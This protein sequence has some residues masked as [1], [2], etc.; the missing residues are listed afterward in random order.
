MRLK[1]MPDYGCYPLWSDVR[2]GDVDPSSLPLSDGLVADLLEWSDF[3]DSKLVWDDP[4]STHWSK[5]EAVS[6]NALGERLT[7][8][9]AEELGPGYAVRYFQVISESDDE[10]RG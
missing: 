1:V 6:F 10:P 5:E 8:R 3:F 2:L 7:A 9:M 4:A